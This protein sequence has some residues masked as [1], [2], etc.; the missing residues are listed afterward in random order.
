MKLNKITA[1][2]Y[3]SKINLKNRYRNSFLGPIWITISSA[4]FIITISYLSGYI[5]KINMDQKLMYIGAGYIF[6]SYIQYVISKSLYVY[7]ENETLI[8]E[9]PISIMFYINKLTI[10]S[11]LIFTHNLFLLIVLMFYTNSFNINIIYFLIS[12]GLMIIVAFLLSLIISILSTKYKDIKPMVEN[13]L[14]II[15][16]ITPIIWPANII[17]K[18]IIF[19]LNIFYHLIE[20]IRHSIMYGTLKI[21]SILHSL[22]FIIILTPIATFIF[23]KNKN[24]IVF[25]I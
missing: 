12:F 7:E 17:E 19:E 11:L 25:L 10:T 21:D 22:I 3:L 13:A 23:Q 2:W 6:W 1:L 15:F 14:F 20:A 24:K 5:S 8:K 9:F 16:V 4:F 18:N